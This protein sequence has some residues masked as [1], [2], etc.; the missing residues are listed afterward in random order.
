MIP[1]KELRSMLSS[2]VQPL[3]LTLVREDVLLERI[4]AASNAASSV[5]PLRSIE[6]SAQHPAKLSSPNEVEVSEVQLPRSTLA[7]AVQP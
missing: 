4:V 2:A 3:K 6:A 1:V 7:S 5:Q